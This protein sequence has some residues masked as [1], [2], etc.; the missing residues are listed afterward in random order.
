M[1][2]LGGPR[3]HVA[4]ARRRS[5]SCRAISA[6]RLQAFREIV[7]TA[8]PSLLAA[9]RLVP[10]ER[11]ERRRRRW[12]PVAR[13]HLANGARL[14][15]LNWMGDTSEAGIQRSLGLMVNYVYRLDAV[16]KNHEAYAR[17]YR[18]RRVARVRA[19]AQTCEALRE[20]VHGPAEAGHYVL[21]SCLACGGED[22][23]G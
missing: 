23:I 6:R 13:F 22:P 3:A 10:V 19:P 8:A 15:R 21:L 16:E 4:A 11:E 14:E 17:D 18:D 20:H 1:A 5:S 7:A 9:V 2:A 12:T